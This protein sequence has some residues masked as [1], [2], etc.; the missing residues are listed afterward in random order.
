MIGGAAQPAQPAQAAA[1]PEASSTPQPT[2][3][4]VALPGGGWKQVTTWPGG[5]MIQLSSGNGM[6]SLSFSSSQTFSA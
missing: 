1:A 6:F 3:E 5:Q 4:R 2:S